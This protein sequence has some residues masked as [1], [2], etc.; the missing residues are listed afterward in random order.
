MT[1]AWRWF[2]MFTAIGAAA[3]CGYLTTN[4][5]AAQEGSCGT[6]GACYRQNCPGRCGATSCAPQF[7][8]DPGT[9]GSFCY[10]CNIGGS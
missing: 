6:A 4:S 8:P 9:L 3:A 1:R 7:C 2:T 10:I 5:V